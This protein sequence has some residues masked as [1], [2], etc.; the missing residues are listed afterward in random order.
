MF[1]RKIDAIF[2]L[3]GLSKYVNI[4]PVYSDIYFANFDNFSQ[5]L[6]NALGHKLHDIKLHVFEEG[7]ASYSSFANFYSDLKYFY[8]GNKSGIKR[9]LHK[10]LYKTKVIPGNLEEFLAFN[11]QLI[12]WNPECD[13]NVL[14]KIDCSDL[15]F[16]GIVQ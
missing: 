16:R 10:Y 5:I 3:Y 1:T 15:K 11:P 13:I 7:L 6:Y 8:G 2:P 4:K 9:F 14:K 12:Q